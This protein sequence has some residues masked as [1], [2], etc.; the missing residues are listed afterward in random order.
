MRIFPKLAEL[1]GQFV[2]GTS[3]VKQ[4]RV[5]S[6]RCHDTYRGMP[7]DRVDHLGH[8]KVAGN[9]IDCYLPVSRLY[10]ALP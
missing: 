9:F 1:V 5:A 8:C 2:F 4:I 7:V 3:H 10:S 6:L